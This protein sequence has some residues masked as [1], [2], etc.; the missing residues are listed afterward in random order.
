VV[1]KRVE[2]VTLDGLGLRRTKAKPT[3]QVVLKAMEPG[4]NR[5]IGVS[6]VP[7]SGRAG[8]IARVDFFELLDG[9]PI[10]GFSLGTRLGSAK[11]AVKHTIER[12]RSVFTRLAALGH[13]DAEVEIKTARAALRKLP[14]PAAW[15]AGVHERFDAIAELLAAGGA[16]KDRL[17]G[18]RKA[19]DGKPPDALVALGCILERV[20]IAITMTTLAAGSRADILQTARWQAELFDVGKPFAS[21]P[22]AAIVAEPTLKFVEAYGVRKAGEKDYAGLLREALPAF[23]ALKQRGDR[24]VFEDL[25]GALRQAV[26]AGDPTPLQGAHR[27]V[28]LHLAAVADR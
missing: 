16:N 21:D 4:E 24:A 10:N 22:A 6:F 5:W 15:I 7:P 12:H 2:A 19:L 3:G 11:D 26:E 8:E 28:L 27:A 20:D 14:T 23:T 9:S 17:D 13:G 25:L 18:I 1:L